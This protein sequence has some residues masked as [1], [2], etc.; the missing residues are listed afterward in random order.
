MATGFCL[1]SHPRPMR[2]SKQELKLTMRISRLALA[3]CVAFCAMAS[4]SHAQRIVDQ[5]R[6]I[7]G[8]KCAALGFERD[9]FEN[10]L[11]GQAG[12][13]LFQR[14]TGMYSAPG[15]EGTLTNVSLGASAGGG[16]GAD[17]LE[18]RRDETEDAEEATS[19][20]GAL[21]FFLSFNNSNEERANTY[22]EAG[23]RSSATGLVLGLDYRLGAS[24]ILGLAVSSRS[25]NG[26]YLE[27]RG[28]FDSDGRTAMLYGSWWPFDGFFVD[29]S[30]GRGEGATN[31]SRIISLY[32]QWDSAG[33]PPST[34]REVLIPPR[35]LSSRSDARHTLADLALGY[36]F[37]FG[38]L[39]L[40]PRLSGNLRQSRTPAFAE[41]GN[42]DAALV[43]H[44]SKEDS[45]RGT[46]GVQ[47][48]AA[49]SAE[50]GVWVVQL[51]GDY[52][53][54]FRDDQ[55]VLSAHLVE[56]LR[57]NPYVITYNDDAPD[58]QMYLAR[59]NIS[60][61]FANGISV[62]GGVDYLLEHDYFDRYMV[63]FGVRKEF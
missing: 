1:E 60:G 57:A 29:V 40:G 19:T 10:I 61:V 52:V 47:A 14:C 63:S 27:T 41:T 54:E 38:W 48:S 62:F 51:N 15:G 13:N 24:G 20:L 45:L 30:V 32:T 50:S 36:D 37:T 39:T 23:R 49:V 59:C 5:Y 2:P 43:Y 3:A 21:S 25:E 44:A 58:R 12:P 11:P 16:L 7:F 28:T 42:T 6:N 26:T 46:A 9:E 53:R 4:P 31:S 34:Y 22:F 17:F 35:L 56:D 18:R 55:R 33:P 8:Q